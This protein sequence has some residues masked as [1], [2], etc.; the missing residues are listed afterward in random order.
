MNVLMSR[1]YY[2]PKIK[3]D[4][5]LYVKTYLLCQQDKGITQKEADLLQPLPIP[6][7]PWTSISMDFIS[8]LPKVKGIG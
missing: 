4:I 5:E 7:N 8:N 2:W 3:L 1:S 6:E